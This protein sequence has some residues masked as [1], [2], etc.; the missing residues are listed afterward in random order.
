M[1]E[2]NAEKHQAKAKILFDPVGNRD[3]LLD[4]I[5]TFERMRREAP[6][7][8]QP[9]TLAPIVNVFRYED[10][11][12]IL[13][14][15]ESFANALP[16]DQFKNAFADPHNLLAM[17][18]PGHTQFRSVVKKVFTPKMVLTLE[19]E[20][21]RNCKQIVSQVLEQR[22]FDCIEDFAAK[23][24]VFMICQLAGVPLCDQ[25]LM[26][27]WTRKAGELGFDS[28][29]DSEPNEGR[30]FAI[31]A[32]MQ[33]MHDYFSALIKERVR[34]PQDDIFSQLAHS[35]LSRQECISFA[36]LLIVAGNETT[37]NLINNSIRLLIDNPDQQTIL[38]ANPALIPNAIE[39]VLRYWP[40]I[41]VTFRTVKHAME[42]NGVPLFEG[43]LVWPW[44][45]SANRDE[46]LCDNPNTLDITRKRTQHV[47]FGQGIHIC[48]G[49][50]LARL[51]TKVMLETVFEET[52]G[53]VRVRD[54]CMEPIDSI[55]SN[56]LEHQFVRFDAS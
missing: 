55:I 13:R 17:D 8:R 23:L 27:D 43:D 36:R 33:E 18:P 25:S 3:F 20:I 51:E 7:Y 32:L 10:V 5:S 42:I 35:G 49:N 12:A 21:R 53:I 44:L 54:D 30:Q 38:R 1:R 45:M 41:R 29:W 31:N 37:T 15:A 34:C 56:G 24:T 2:E 16:E 50:A 9:G 11:M 52:T 48:L 39:E 22:E 46:A 19:P 6:V 40:S 47:A 26:R 4:P 28:L 14:N